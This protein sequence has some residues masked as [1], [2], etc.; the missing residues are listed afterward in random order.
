M[1]RRLITGGIF[2][3][4]LTGIYVTVIRPFVDQAREVLSGSLQDLEGVDERWQ[5]L[6]VPESFTVP[7]E[8]LPAIP[9]QMLNVPEEMLQGLI[10]IVMQDSETFI[11]IYLKVTEDG[12]V[13]TAASAGNKIAIIPVARQWET[14]DG[15]PAECSSR[16]KITKADPWEQDDHFYVTVEFVGD[17]GQRLVSCTNYVAPEFTT[18]WVVDVEEYAELPAPWC[19]LVVITVRDDI[20]DPPDLLSQKY[21]VQVEALTF[22][23]CLE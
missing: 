3:I 5:D 13:K 10:V 22:C 16:F 17:E 11:E 6:G 23:D 12:L 7:V 18:E 1:K 2:L 20:S 8:D 15:E 14:A 9:E 19:G 21:Q 4:L